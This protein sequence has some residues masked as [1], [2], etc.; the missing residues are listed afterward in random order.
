MPGPHIDACIM[1]C[2]P[3]VGGVDFWLSSWHHEGKQWW[4]GWHTRKPFQEFHIGEAEDWTL[5]GYELWHS[6]MDHEQWCGPGYMLEAYCADLTPPQAHG[7][8]T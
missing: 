7:D 2:F 8:Q 1:Q 6:P 3:D 4:V 5:I